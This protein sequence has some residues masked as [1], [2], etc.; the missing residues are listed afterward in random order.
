LSRRPGRDEAGSAI[1]DFVLVL[2]VLIPVFLGILQLALTLHV[3]NVL[4]SAASE[5]A[6]HGAT[7][8]R[9]PADGVAKAHGQ[10][11]GALNESYADNIRAE[12]TTIGGAPAVRIVI[13]AVVP[14]LG[15]GGPGV[16]LTVR[17]TAVDEDIP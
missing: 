5:G 13:R 9:E 12:A 7:L 2:V 6:R 1:V 3:R 17:G 14:A 4:A 11:V 16:P 15:I 10:I 8:D